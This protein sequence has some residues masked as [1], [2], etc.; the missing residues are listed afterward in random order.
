MERLNRVFSATKRIVR[1]YR[2]TTHTITVFYF[3]A[4]KIRFLQSQGFTESSGE[5]QRPTQNSKCE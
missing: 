4:G 1:G 2:S 5:P 3:V